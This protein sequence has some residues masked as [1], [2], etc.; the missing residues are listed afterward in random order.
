MLKRLDVQTLSHPVCYKPIN[1]INLKDFLYYDKDGFELNQA[2]QNYYYKMNYPLNSCLN[3]MCFQQNWFISEI[4][5]II[6][7]HCL[8]LHRCRYEDEALEQLNYLSKTIPQA[9]L[10]A[11]T[12]AKW[13][14]DFAL[15]SIDSEGNVFEVLHVEYD[16]YNYFKFNEK[17]IS[18]DFKIRHTDW[19]D[20]ASK[21]IQHKEEWANLKGFEQNHW[22]AKFLIGWNKAEYTEKSN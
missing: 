5:D 16:D 7:D 18:F 3:H 13:G 10:L 21:I 9:S 2:E 8:I 19:I 6:I 1:F 4:K 14:F 22:K 17:M 20:A 15:D 12:R 11:N